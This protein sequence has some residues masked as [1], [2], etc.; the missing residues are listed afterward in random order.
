M[1]K[2]NL[3]LLTEIEFWEKFYLDHISFML[4]QDKNKMIRAIKSKD[5]IKE[6]WIHIKF[7]SSDVARGA[8]R[9][10]H[11]LLSQLG[12]PNSTPIGSDILFETTNVLIHIDIKTSSYWTISKG[13]KRKNTGDFVGK[14]S[15]GGNQTSYQYVEK[16]DDK[17]IIHTA[18]LPTKYK[19]KNKLCLTYVIHLV[20]D[21]GDDGDIKV[22]SLLIICVPNGLLK[23]V[24]G[25]KIC[26]GSKNVGDAF[27]YVYSEKPTFELL[28]NKPYRFEFLYLEPSLQEKKEEIL[29]FKIE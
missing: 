9:I 19:S 28:D 17:K 8:E 23:K 5:D 14:V 22:I 29:G 6:D 3:K 11:W 7:K 13:K 10:Y 20:Y 2:K 26:T 1:N 16:K 27:R 24:Y 25:N 4:L 18:N 21:K 15:I 12:I